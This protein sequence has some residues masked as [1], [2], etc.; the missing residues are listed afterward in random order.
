ME[1]APNV[2]INATVS[3]SFSVNLLNAQTEAGTSYSTTVGSTVSTNIRINFDLACWA[4]VYN[5]INLLPSISCDISSRKPFP[6]V[7]Y[8]LAPVQN[9]LD[10]EDDLAGSQQ[11]MEISNHFGNFN[12]A[13]PDDA[14]DG[15]NTINSD[16]NED[17]TDLTLNS[18]SQIKDSMIF[19]GYY[20]M[21]INDI[22]PI[23]PIVIP[24]VAT[25][26][27]PFVFSL[28]SFVNLAAGDTKTED[29]SEDAEAEDNTS[30]KTVYS[31]YDD[32]TI[33]SCSVTIG[34]D[35]I[36]LEFSSVKLTICTIYK[37]DSHEDANVIGK[38]Y[39]WVAEVQLTKDGKTYKS[40][41]TE[42]FNYTIINGSSFSSSATGDYV[43][44]NKITLK[45]TSNSEETLDYTFIFR[46]YSTTE[47]AK[48]LTLQSPLFSNACCCYFSSDSEQSTADI[49]YSTVSDGSVS[50][51]V[52]NTIK[53][54]AS[55][56]NFSPYE[57]SV[58]AIGS[59]YAIIKTGNSSNTDGSSSTDG[60]SNSNDSSG[61]DG[62]SNS[63]D[64][65]G[66]D[67]SSNSND[68]SGTDGS[69]NSNDSSGTDGSSNSN[70]SSGTDG[71]SSSNDSSGTDGSSN[72]NDSSGTDGS[73][74]SNDSSGTDGS[75]SSNS[76][77]NEG[78]AALEID[79]LF[80]W[81]SKKDTKITDTTDSWY[82]QLTGSSDN[83]DLKA[84]L[85]CFDTEKEKLQKDNLK[86]Y[87]IN[88]EGSD[89]QTVEDKIKCA[90][91]V[92]V[93]GSEVV[94]DPAGYTLNITLTLLK[95]SSKYCFHLIIDK[96]DSHKSVSSYN[97]MKFSSKADEIIEP[98]I[99]VGS[100]L[101]N[102]F[103]TNFSI[104]ASKSS[105][106]DVGID[107][108]SM[109]FD[110][111]RF[112]Y[113][114]TTDLI[115]FYQLP[116][117]N[118]DDINELIKSDNSYNNMVQILSS[119][120]VSVPEAILG[121][122]GAGLIGLKFAFKNTPQLMFDANKDDQGTFYSFAKNKINLN[123]TVLQMESGI[124]IAEDHI[125]TGAEGAIVLKVGDSCVTLG[126]KQDVNIELESKKFK[127]NLTNDKI[128]LAEK[129][130][131]AKVTLSEN[132][133]DISFGG[134]ASAVL[135]QDGH[136]LKAAKNVNLFKFN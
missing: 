73:S 25:A 23:K 120:A 53:N 66:T 6:V 82:T 88:F 40:E 77:S 130:N 7:S 95:Y 89:E 11:L 68:S 50:N 70:D 37:N 15:N 47:D 56:D 79:E 34:S 58:T 127:I 63:N 69:S 14:Q 105:Y 36:Q 121:G 108:Y 17:A 71:S 38:K 31:T 67:D 5:V 29:Q 80:Y 111:F 46:I 124:E 49:S 83:S 20:G 93:T 28:P 110:F 18:Y 44:T 132:K 97:R 1:Y 59:D 74:N 114:D 3:D 55:T 12:A 60:S 30:D 10:V 43:T 91:I 104:Y 116:A 125:Y 115:E 32:A 2:E 106:S 99:M 103:T 76:S 87:K 65:S 90:R 16:T 113:N 117:V 4:G 78:F 42:V 62:S 134:A 92:D 57:R 136:V 19:N 75:S 51:V 84:V 26:I 100:N 102:L 48:T 72:S 9:Q 128:V 123:S 22:G 131:K 94:V 54:S 52:T 101:K 135:D 21:E 39:S 118:T 86:A 126:N 112:R 107:S 119:G 64:S 35:T 24:F 98:N 122:V 109:V 45:N 96:D 33:D 129:S 41:S 81:L 85:T 61:T 13:L 27:S 8:P 133:F